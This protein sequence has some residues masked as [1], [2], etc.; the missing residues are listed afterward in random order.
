M[1]PN[2][3]AGFSGVVSSTNPLGIFVPCTNF[4]YFDWSSSGGIPA[5]FSLVRLV[6]AVVSVSVTPGIE[7]SAGVIHGCFLPKNQFNEWRGISVTTADDVMNLPQVQS[8][9]IN[10]GLTMSIRYRPADNECWAY[11][12][13]NYPLPIPTTD[14]IYFP[15]TFVVCGTGFDN[16]VE[17]TVQIQLNMEGI[18]RFSQNAK[19]ATAS[20]Y[21]PAALDHAAN[22]VANMPCVTT[23]PRVA[24]PLSDE[25]YT[26]TDS[27][28][29]RNDKGRLSNIAKHTIT[30]KLVAGLD[31]PTVDPLVDGA[32][33][34]LVPEDIIDPQKAD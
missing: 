26:S 17:M 33:S 7:D 22:L 30:S 14:G 16:N 34:K 9:A 2:Y 8:V 6:S 27:Q 32:V 11:C 13:T 20:Y 31:A 25:G 24:I 18:P 29:T 4:T 1:G 19:E 10:S 23:D 15:G 12:S 28:D 3:I 21:D 5:R